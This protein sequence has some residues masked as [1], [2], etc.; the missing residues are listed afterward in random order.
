MGLALDEDHQP[1]LTKERL[2]AWGEQVLTVFGLI[3]AATST[4]HE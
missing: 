3:E 4:V 2:D 1:K